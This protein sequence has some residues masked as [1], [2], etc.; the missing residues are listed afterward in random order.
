MLLACVWCDIVPRVRSSRANVLSEM[1]DSDSDL[2]ESEVEGQSDEDEDILL[3]LSSASDESTTPVESETETHARSQV[4][5]GRP[6]AQRERAP[7]R[8]NNDL[9]GKDGTV[10]VRQDNNQRGR[11]G[12]MSD[13]NAFEEILGPLPLNETR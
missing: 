10:W 4:R 12:R 11:R 1:P 3:E 7:M 8:V 13:H 9:I 2:S 6:R 5:R